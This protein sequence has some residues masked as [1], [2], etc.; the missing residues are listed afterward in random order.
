MKRM[1][2]NMYL[3]LFSFLSFFIIY[4]DKDV[5]INMDMQV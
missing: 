5:D 2:T 3:A 4:K 1:D